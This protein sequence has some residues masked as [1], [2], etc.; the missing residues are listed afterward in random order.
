M[1]YCRETCRTQHRHRGLLTLAVWATLGTLLLVACGDP[2]RPTQTAA[3][4]T[5]TV[6]QPQLRPRVVTKATTTLASPASV[7]GEQITIAASGG[8][9]FVQ[10]AAGENHTCALRGDGRVECWGTNDQ[11]QLDVPRDAGFQ[12]VTSGWRFSCGIQIDDTINCWGRNNHQQADPPDGTFQAVDAGWDHACGLSGTTAV[13]WGRDANERATPPPDVGFTAIGAGAEHSCGLSTAGDLVCW[14]KN[15]NGRADSRSGPFQVL[16]VGIAHTCVLDGDGRASCQ[17][18]NSS[19]QS[20][21][22]DSVFMEIDAGADHTCGTLASGHVECWGGRQSGAAH[23]PF[24]PPGKYTSVSAGWL[25][26][27][28]TNRRGQTAC[29]S[30]TVRPRGPEPYDVLLFANDYPGLTFSEPTDV[31]SLPTGDLAIT[32]RFGGILVL[33]PDSSIIPVLDLADIVKRDGDEQGLLSI[34]IDPRGN[35]FSFMYLLYTIQ[36]PRDVDRAISRLSRMPIVDGQ[37]VRE[38]ELIMLEIPRD[39]AVAGHYGGAIRF[40][41]DGMLHLGLGDAGCFD[42]PQRLDSLHGKILR[43]DVRE[44]TLDSPYR[45]PEDNPMRGLEDARP[46]IWAYGLRNPWRMAFDAGDGRLW[47]GDV[48]NS[49]YEEVSI[50]T[51]GANLGWPIME[52]FHCLE[53]SEVLRRWYGVSA[54]MPC[55]DIGRFAQPVITYGHEGKCAIVGGLVYRGNEMPWLNGRYLFGDYCS[56]QVWALDGDAEAGWRMVEIADFDFPLSSFGTNANGEILAL[57]FGGPLLRLVEADSG[58][59]PLV[60]HTPLATIVTIPSGTIDES[61]RSR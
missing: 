52:G 20:E 29:W 49:T 11:G 48:G 43:I 2:S 47:V 12:Q 9:G 7:A 17:G 28:A 27:C 33:A 40:G 4:P 36:D 50:V 57:T 44:A 19:G 41:P 23:G 51:R 6:Q 14:G 31:I 34:A 59:A 15:D 37:P 39:S 21:P 53:F 10:V 30:T 25:S 35:E 13:C 42:C 16:S 46:E 38:Q 22:P 55:K 1:I 45:I 5:P 26:S 18:E 60:T 24:G 54:V 56:G 61:D 58:F 8:P 32:D 3:E